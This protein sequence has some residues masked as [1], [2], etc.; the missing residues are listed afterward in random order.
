MLQLQE[1]GIALRL[2]W[3][4]NVGQRFM[5]IRCTYKVLKEL[6]ITT[7][8]ISGQLESVGALEEWYVNL[9]Y[10]NRRKRLIFTNAGALF[11]FVVAD[12]LRKDI[13][14]LQELF[15]KEL[16][17]ALFYEEFSARQIQEIM[18][19]AEKITIAKTISRSVLASMNQMIFEYG[20][21]VDKYAHLE[22][23]GMIT[24][25]RKLNKLLRGAIGKGRHDYGAPVERFKEIIAEHKFGKFHVN[26]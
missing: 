18:K 20:H 8:Q 12:V 1:Q 7:S 10:S 14:N 2:S 15:R 26:N 17:R 24:A 6:K 3:G 9:F 13:Q 16:S 23:E 11:S 22:N 21:M 19:R 5:I 4:I 25:S